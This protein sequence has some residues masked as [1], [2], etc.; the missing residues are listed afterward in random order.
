MFAFEKELVFGSKTS[1]CARVLAITDF[2]SDVQLVH[3]L[4]QHNRSSNFKPRG[5]AIILLAEHSEGFACGRPDQFL[6]SGLA[7]SST[8]TA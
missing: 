8:H 6:C 7:Q 5:V 1:A 2:L 4:G 3:R